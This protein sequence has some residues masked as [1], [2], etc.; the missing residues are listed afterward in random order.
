MQQPQPANILALDPD[1]EDWAQQSTRF[2]PDTGT[3]GILLAL[4]ACS[5]VTLY[6]FGQLGISGVCVCVRQC[7]W[8]AGARVHRARGWLT[9]PTPRC[10]PPPPT[11]RALAC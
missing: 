4:Q 3:Y 8:Q 2:P 1:F 5:S 11:P 6:G 7:V 10:P 9:P